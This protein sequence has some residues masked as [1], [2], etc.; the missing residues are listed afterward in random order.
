MG[1]RVISRARGNSCNSSKPI[2]M[3]DHKFPISKNAGKSVLINMA[4]R[5]E[6][7]LC[8]QGSL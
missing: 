4:K 8:P 7:S 1:L 2:K 3:I 5:R 6:K